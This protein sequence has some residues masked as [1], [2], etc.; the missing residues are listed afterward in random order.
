LTFTRYPG[1]TAIV[2]GTAGT[3]NTIEIDSVTSA[4]LTY[5]TVTGNVVQYGSGI[6]VD[7][8]SGVTLSHLSVHENTSFGIRTSR[9]S[10]VIEQSDIYQN[11]SGIE[12]AH[13]G[14]VTIRNN[15]I[16]NNNKMVDSGVGGQGV[17]FYMTTGPVVASN[18]RIWSNHTL[19]GD[20][21]GPDGTGFEIYGAS[22]VTMTANVMYDNRDLLETGTDSASHPCSHLTFTKNLAYRTDS[23]QTDGIIL[24]CADHSLIAANTLIG[25]DKFAFDISSFFGSYGGSIEGLRILDNLIVNGRTY[26]IDNPI[27]AS[28]VMDYNLAY[29]T[30]SA[31]A[32]YGTYDAWIEGRDQTSSVSQFRSWTGQAAHDIW[33]S[34]PLLNSSY[35]PTS[36]SPAINAG[37]AIGLPYSGSAPDLGYCE[38][39]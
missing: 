16:H 6:G 36:G 4:T 24:R 8:S 29:T 2:K 26:S 32:E 27:P 31:T 15:N 37:L 18:N 30:A 39:A 28:V 3:Y 38:V 19:P 7:S 17:S 35:C 14:T 23:D 5:L 12:V 9:S 10:A 34:N 20:P 21:M 11:H 13:E 33:G 25:L 22:N 1:E